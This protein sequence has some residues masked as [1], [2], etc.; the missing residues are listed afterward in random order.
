MIQLKDA[1]RI[2]AAAERRPRESV[3]PRSLLSQI[4]GG[5]LIAHVRM[6]G[7]WLGSIDISIKKAYTS[8]AFDIGTKTWR[9]IRNRATGSLTFTLRTMAG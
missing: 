3:N 7:G 5:N 6:D 4:T 9:S 2:I 1:R 8:G